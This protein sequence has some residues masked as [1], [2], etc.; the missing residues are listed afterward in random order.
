MS[1]LWESA[2]NGALTTDLAE[3]S[4]FMELYGKSRSFNTC[5]Y[6]LLEDIGGSSGCSAA[7]GQGYLQIISC[8]MIVRS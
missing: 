8:G 3:A 4:I 7:Y 2:R 6:D 1:R 5:N